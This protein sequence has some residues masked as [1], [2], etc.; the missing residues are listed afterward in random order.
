MPRFDQ[1]V[2]LLTGGAGQIGRATG[3][4][5]A[6]EGARVF[7]VD[8]DEEGL[9]DALAAIPGAKGMVGDAA[10]AADVVSY[11]AA[12]AE[13]GHGRIDLFFNNAGV[14]G[15]ISPTV[16]LSEE[17]FDQV[18]ATNVRGVFLGMKYV[19]PFMADGG[20]IVNTGSTAGV[21]GAPRMLA[22]VASK[23]AV[24]GMTRTVAQ[25]VAE[26]GIRVNAVCPGPIE[27]RMMTSIEKGVGLPDAHERYRASIPAG[28][29]G[30][31]EEVAATVAFLLS[32]DASFITGGVY[33]V[34][35]GQTAH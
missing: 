21:I 35:G 14:E 11:V 31:V 10:E 8:R 18:I 25:E 3:A 20:A 27:G 1:Q 4:R 32:D 30:R 29:Y 7:L 17:A 23:H 16:D 6:A 24:I 12:A 5:L 26:R 34:D 2:A 15:P 22:Y 9:R 33:L 19:L 28:R 13:L